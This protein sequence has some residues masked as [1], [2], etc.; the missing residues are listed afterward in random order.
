MV[1]L[2]ASPGKVMFP[3]R[4]VHFKYVAKRLAQNMRILHADPSWDQRPSR[5]IPAALS[6]S[7]HIFVRVDCV[8]PQLQPPYAGLFRMVRRGRKTFIFDFAGRHDALSTDRANLP[9]WNAGRT[10]D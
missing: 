5:H 6:I 9:L 2:S 1:A 3:S 10:T 4:P 8:R 7:T